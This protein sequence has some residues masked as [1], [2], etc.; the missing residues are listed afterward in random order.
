M[1]CTVP[2]IGVTWV[3]AGGG[4]CGCTALHCIA[5]YCTVDARYGCYLAAGAIVKRPLFMEVCV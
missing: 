1:L 2:G 4:W 3:L 5:L